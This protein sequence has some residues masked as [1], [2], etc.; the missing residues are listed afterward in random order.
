MRRLRPVL[1][2]TLFSVWVMSVSAATL[3]VGAG[4]AY[5]TISA[6]V[7]ASAPSDTIVVHT[8]VYPE[9]FAIQHPLNI[10]EAPGA[11]AKLRTVTGPATALGSKVM[12]EINANGVI[13]EGID[14]VLESSDRTGG[15]LVSGAGELFIR[16]ATFEGTWNPGTYAGTIRAIDTARIMG[17][18]LS[19]TSSAFEEFVTVEGSARVTVEDSDLRGSGSPQ[20]MVNALRPAGGEVNLEIKRS[21]LQAQGSSNLVT[22]IAGHVVME[23]CNNKIPT[24]GIEMIQIRRSLTGAKLRISRSRFD[25]D[26]TTNQ[27]GA[28]ALYMSRGFSEPNLPNNWISPIVEVENCF[29][30]RSDNDLFAHFSAMGGGGELTLTNNTFVSLSTSASSGLWVVQ[31]PNQ[32]TP[33]NIIV[34]HNIFY[35]PNLSRANSAIIRDSPYTEMTVSSTK[36]L[37]FSNS[38]MASDLLNGEILSVDPQ[39]GPDYLHLLATSPAVD[40]AVGSLLTVDYDGGA[41]PVGAAN[42]LGAD[43][44][45]AAA[46][47]PTEARWTE[48]Y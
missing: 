8:G 47:L 38:A 42:D 33:C 2:L 21:R 20:F 37:R 26:G 40:A 13:W 39:L 16:K 44:Y 23:Q 45:G 19:N 48:G 15:I 5:S 32:D 18:E 46:P 43:E 36:N 14:F 11:T 24:G 12:V 4:H 22:I 27:N 41:R 7:A 28:A 3:N 34:N 30:F 10:V 17:R 31:G 25:L 29:F 1:L 9:C 6:A 35:F